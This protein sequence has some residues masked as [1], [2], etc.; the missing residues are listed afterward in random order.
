MMKLNE[1]CN[2]LQEIFADYSCE[3]YSNNGLQVEGTSD[4][5]K[6]AFAVDACLDTIVK[7][8]MQGA[9]ML[10]VHHGL[11]WGDGF[12][13]LTGVDAARFRAL[14]ASNLSLFAMHLPLDA[15]QE[16]G[17]NAVLAQRMGCK[18]TRTFCKCRGVEIGTVCK[19]EAPV[20]LTEL[21]SK[22]RWHI[23]S[24]AKLTDN[25]QGVA[26]GVA[27]VSG[28]GDFAIEMCKDAGADCLVTGEF[29]H[30][31]WHAAHELGVSVISAGHYDTENT[32]VRAL[33]AKVKAE[34]PL[35]TVFIEAPTGL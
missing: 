11:S 24:T 3:D 17:N 19:F 26:N 22:A 1:L 32:G 15:H 23:S 7:A 29:M 31:R 4:V 18:V 35:E 33:M 16:I 30:Q 5:R 2:W 14:F 10:V 6:V 9:D 25:S 13:R 34:L 8:G 21:L 28:G 12:K 27:F 20:P